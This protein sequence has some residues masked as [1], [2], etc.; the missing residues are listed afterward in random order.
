MLMCRGFLNSITMHVVLGVRDME[1]EAH[2]NV[3]MT[4]EKRNESIDKWTQIDEAVEM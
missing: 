4:A 1:G 2:A 3:K